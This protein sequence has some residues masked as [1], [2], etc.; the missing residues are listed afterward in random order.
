MKDWYSPSEI[1][2]NRQQCRWLIENLVY[3]RDIQKWPN[4][5]T[6]YMDN[7]EGHTTSLKAPFLTPVEYAIEISQR[8]EKCGIDGLIL[9]AMVCW[10]ETEDNLARYVGKSPTT[11]AKKGKMA[12]G[13]VASGPVRRWINSKKRPAETYYEFRQRKR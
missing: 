1:R 7:P 3:L 11:I 12:L 10:G 2:F 4:Q 6:G 13:Y 9:L 5:E 8:L